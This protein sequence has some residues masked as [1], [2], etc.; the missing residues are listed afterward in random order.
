MNG[1]ISFDYDQGTSGTEINS[2]VNLNLANAESYLKGN[3]LKMVTHR[4]KNR[5]LKI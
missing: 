1:D 4:R 2:T 3:I 5:P